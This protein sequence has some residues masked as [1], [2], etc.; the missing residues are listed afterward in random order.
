MVPLK[1]GTKLDR[2]TALEQLHGGMITMQDIVD[3]DDRSV[4]LLAVP[5]NTPSDNEDHRKQSVPPSTTLDVHLHH[6][7]KSVSNDEDDREQSVPPNIPSD[8][9]L[10]HALQSMSSN[11]DDHEQ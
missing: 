4:S 2:C 8:A 7:P 5:S 1:D 11:K 6:G 3:K 9:H 10:S